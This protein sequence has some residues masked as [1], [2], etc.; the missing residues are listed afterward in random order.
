MACVAV[1][2]SGGRDSTALLHCTVRQ[3]QDLGI[4]VLALHVHHGLMPQADDWLRQV[5]RQAL[6]W[7]ATFASRRLTGKPARG[8][9][10][11]AWAHRTLPR[12]GRY[13]C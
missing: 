6:R 10:V 4:E 7:G 13:G 2:A 1:A 11:E 12:A 8:Q 9:S 3:A 5:Q